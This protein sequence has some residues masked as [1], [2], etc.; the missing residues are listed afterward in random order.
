MSG[1]ENALERD[2]NESDDGFEVVDPEL[3]EESQDPKYLSRTSS[4]GNAGTIVSS[5]TFLI[6]RVIILHGS[7]TFTII[8]IKSRFCV[9]EIYSVVW[10]SVLINLIDFIFFRFLHISMT[11]ITAS[12]R[13][14]ANMFGRRDGP[15]KRMT[16]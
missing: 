12:M 9:D 5:P 8:W 10:A 3:D 2:A 6:P 1:S 7:I 15:R 4:A 16:W 11:S 13:L 14:N